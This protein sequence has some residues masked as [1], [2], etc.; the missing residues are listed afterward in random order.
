MSLHSD[1]WGGAMGKARGAAP[2]TAPDS[3]GALGSLEERVEA[4]RSLWWRAGRQAQV[5]PNFDDHRRI[6]N[7]RE[8]D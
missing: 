5:A 1:M 4:G 3:V 6:F 8:D 2:G 7:G